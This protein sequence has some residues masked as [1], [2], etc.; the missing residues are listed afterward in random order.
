MHKKGK[1]LIRVWVA[2]KQKSLYP[3]AEHNARGRPANLPKK[4]VPKFWCYDQKGPFL[5]CHLT[6]LS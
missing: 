4:G 5:G 6:N 3:L 1:G 2:T